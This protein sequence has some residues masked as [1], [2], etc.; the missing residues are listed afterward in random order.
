MCTCP[1]TQAYKRLAL[2]LHPD[3]QSR[4][5]TPDQLNAVALKLVRAQHGEPL[6][7][8]AALE[9]VLARHATTV[10]IDRCA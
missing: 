7:L 10:A 1:A 8:A 9:C 4:D 3:K 6:S 5:A 2:T